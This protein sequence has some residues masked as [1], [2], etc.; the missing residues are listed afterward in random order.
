[1]SLCSLNCKHQKC[2]C[3]PIRMQLQLLCAEWHKGTRCI[4]LNV[5]STYCP[6]LRS[7]FSYGRTCSKV[8]FVDHTLPQSA[9]RNST[10]LWCPSRNIHRRH[11]RAQRHPSLG[12]FPHY[13]DQRHS[14][15]QHVNT[16]RHTPKP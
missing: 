13:C 16:L 12:R 3:A 4:V 8:N 7:R 9:C 14:F 1:M 10:R 15:V 6:N 2:F 5:A 11:P